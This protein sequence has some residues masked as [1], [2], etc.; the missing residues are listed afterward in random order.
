ML[1][2]RGSQAVARS[3]FRLEWSGRVPPALNSPCTPASFSAASA[4]SLAARPPLAWGSCQS[5][6]SFHL[7]MGEEG[8]PCYSICRQVTSVSSKRIVHFR[9]NEGSFAFQERPWVQVRTPGH[10]WEGASLRVLL[11][12][13]P[14]SVQRPRSPLPNRKTSA[15]IQRACQLGEGSPSS[16]RHPAWLRLCTP[17]PGSQPDPPGMEARRPLPNAAPRRSSPVPAS[18]RRPEGCLAHLLMSLTERHLGVAG[19]QYS[20]KRAWVLHTPRKREKVSTGRLSPRWRHTA[21]GGRRV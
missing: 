19:T 7:L 13:H 1:A 9:N 2:Q 15:G 4:E 21:R 10:R 6:R 11:Q 16:P 18:L 17:A 20:G 5:F 14:K 3:K 12:A 8:N